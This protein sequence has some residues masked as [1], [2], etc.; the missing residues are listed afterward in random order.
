M[1]YISQNTQPITGGLR[2]LSL[3]LIVLLDEINVGL[4]LWKRVALKVV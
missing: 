3:T 2:T 4:A 1:N